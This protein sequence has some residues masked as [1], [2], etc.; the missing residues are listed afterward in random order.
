[1]RMME[2]YWASNPEWT[3]FDEDLRLQIRE[4]A[5]EKAKESF[6]KYKKQVA[7]YTKFKQEYRF[8]E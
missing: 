4:D 3:Y 7:E 2:G 8:D 1:M 5:L 6:V